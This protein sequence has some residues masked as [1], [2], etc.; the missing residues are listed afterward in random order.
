MDVKNNMGIHFFVEKT[1]FMWYNRNCKIIGNN[2]AILE[3]GKW[4]L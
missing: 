3:M 2:W 4:K 1:R